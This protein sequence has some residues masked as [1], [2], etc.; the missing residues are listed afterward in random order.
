MPNGKKSSVVQSI[1]ELEAILSE[2]AFHGDRF[3]GQLA[4]SVISRVAAH[5]AANASI[6]SGVM[7]HEL[8]ADF[9]FEMAVARMQSNDVDRCPVGTLLAAAKSFRTLGL[10]SDHL[11]TRN[12]LNSLLWRARS[13]TMQELCNMLSFCSAQKVASTERNR[14]LVEVSDAFERRWVEVVEPATFVA[15]LHYADMFSEGFLN[16][17]EDRLTELV[18]SMSHADMVAVS[19]SL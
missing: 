10:P 9:R 14:L 11:A 2:V 15:I 8:Q 13:S 16:K 19:S 18:G 17:V 3:H 6:D 12:I 7:L 5:V 4:A 1:P